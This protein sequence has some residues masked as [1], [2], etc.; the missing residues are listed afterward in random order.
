MGTMEVPE[1]VPFRLTHN[2]VDAFGPLVFD[3]LVDWA[4]GSKSGGANEGME[5]LRRVQER[6]TGNI[7][8]SMKKDQ[9]K[10]SIVSHTLSVEGQ[11]KHVIDQATAHDNLAVMYWGWAPYL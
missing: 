11:V 5:A 3:P 4:K 10:K 6:L 9:R 7:T 2:M 1:V 8:S